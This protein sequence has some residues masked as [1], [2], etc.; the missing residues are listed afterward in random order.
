MSNPCHG[1]VPPKRQLYCHSGC[2]GYLK[3]KDQENIY[4]AAEYE[5][6]RNKHETAAVRRQSIQRMT[7]KKLGG[8]Y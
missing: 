4:K 3:F 2:D 8:D 6:N 7:S 5:K 1:C